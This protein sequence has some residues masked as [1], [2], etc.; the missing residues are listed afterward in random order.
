MPVI[1]TNRMTN[2]RPGHTPQTERRLTEDIDVIHVALNYILR[3]RDYD[4]SWNEEQKDW[5]GWL[6]HMPS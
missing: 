6:V 4:P 2:T 5:H 3:V 1:T